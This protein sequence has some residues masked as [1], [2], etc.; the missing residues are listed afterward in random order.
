MNWHSRVIQVW[1]VVSAAW[2]GMIVWQTYGL[3]AA[4][5]SEPLAFLILKYLALAIVPPLG[6]AAVVAL[7]W[8]AALVLDAVLFRFPRQPS[9]RRVHHSATP[10]RMR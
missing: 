10:Q 8:L 3:M 6:I 4:G 7:M 5:A 2:V 9:A 1:I